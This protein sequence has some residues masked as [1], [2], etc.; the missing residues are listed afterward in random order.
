MLSVLEKFSAGSL[1]LIYIYLNI[2][3]VEIMVSGF[4]Y[5]S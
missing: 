2:D 4:L 5:S 3:G 1:V